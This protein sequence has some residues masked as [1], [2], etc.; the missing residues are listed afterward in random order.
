T[1]IGR[2]APSPTGA[3]HIGNA[4]TY[5]VAWL[6]ARTNAGRLLLR[7][8]D[9]DT[10]RTKT[11]AEAL[12]FEDLNWLGLDWDHDLS[13]QGFIRQSER[14][15][16]YTDVLDRL[17]SLELVYPCTCTRSEIEEAASA[18]HETFLDGTVYRGKCSTNCVADALRFDHQGLRY[19]W[20][21]RFPRMQ[22]V[23]WADQFAGPQSLIPSQSLGDFVVAR[24]YGP[25][26]YQLAVVVDD[27]DSGITH[28][29]RGNDLIFSTYRQLAIYDA[30]Q[31]E[32]PTW[33]HLP[34]VVG[35]DG[36]RLAKRH[37]DS[38]LSYYRELGTKPEELL[39]AIARSLCLT[40]SNTPLNANQ[41][42]G[43]AQASPAWLRHIP[44][45]PFSWFG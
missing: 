2:L 34:L 21:F 13:T 3:Q 7:I 17:K 31:W 4:R 22:E 25:V 32:P 20:R 33:I 15:T 39:G 44:A 42:L 11:G 35:N 18:P 6:H 37:G 45:K 14:T 38:R 1:Y 8:E 10:P 36:R 9:L 16:R 28:V 27:H 23:N 29:A 5:L 40:S 30:M 43:L 41:I 24:N 26:A 19:A 12:I